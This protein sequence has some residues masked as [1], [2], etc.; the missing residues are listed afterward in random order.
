M[1][2]NHRYASEQYYMDGKNKTS[3]QFI[4]LVYLK[5]TWHAAEGRH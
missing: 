1:K 3:K 2:N 5:S 4:E